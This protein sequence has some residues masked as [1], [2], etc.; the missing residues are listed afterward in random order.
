VIFFGE[1]KGI[2]SV[3]ALVFLQVQLLTQNK[4]SEIGK[5]F[6]LFDSLAGRKQR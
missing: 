2:L 4:L 6:E 3:K 1:M 5:S